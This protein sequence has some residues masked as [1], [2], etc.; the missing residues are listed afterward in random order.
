MLLSGKTV[1]VTGGARRI[2]AAICL[3][4]AKEGGNVVIHHGHSDQMALETAN[5]IRATGQKAYI[6]KSNLNEPDEVRSLFAKARKKTQIDALVNNAA[7]FSPQRFADTT[8]E[9]WQQNLMVNLT[10]PFLLS[11][12][13]AKEGRGRIV[14]ILDWRSL[15]PGADHFAYTIAKAGLAAMTKSLAVALA[16]GIVVNGLALGAILPPSDSSTIPQLEHLIPLK[17]WANLNEVTD[18]VLF[19]LSGPEY[20][21]GEILHLDGGRHLI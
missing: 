21:T 15:R 2:G 12:A 9:I 6:V 8:L 4:I 1:L 11:K 10:A 17:R 13:F 16:P 3:A 14:N 18:A 5:E 7:I 19:L 20:I